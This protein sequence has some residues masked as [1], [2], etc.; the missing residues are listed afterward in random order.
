[1][2][3]SFKWGSQTSLYGAGFA[4][5]SFCYSVYYGRADWPSYSVWLVPGTV[6]DDE[7]YEP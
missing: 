2:L 4:H 1:M 5:A 7:R 6:R 3:T